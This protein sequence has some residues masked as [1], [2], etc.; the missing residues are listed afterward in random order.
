MSYATNS[1]QGRPGINNV[2]NNFYINIGRVDVHNGDIN[3]GIQHTVA[4]QKVGDVHVYNNIENVVN[5]QTNYVINMDNRKIEFV[6]PYSTNRD[7]GAG[8]VEHKAVPQIEHNYNPM[9]SYQNNVSYNILKKRRPMVQFV[10]DA[11]QVSPLVEATFIE[12]TGEEFPK[13]IVVHVC[14]EDT[15]KKAHA[16]WGGVWNP[17]IMGFAI[18]EQRAVFVKKGDLDVLMLTLGHEIG[19]VLTPTLRDAVSEE[20]KAFAFELAWVKKIIEK[21]IGGLAGNFDPDFVPAAN[22]LH[23][24]AFGF[25]QKLVKKGRKA[26]EVFKELAQGAIHVT[27]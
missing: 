24:K 17:G 1:Y 2:V 26:V 23:D 22:G 11:E 15:M 13:D 9:N 12:L 10:K 25:V 21:N 27:P 16:N 14:D 3:N 5:N 6:S 20:A 4:A 19:H 18:N 7:A 8:Y